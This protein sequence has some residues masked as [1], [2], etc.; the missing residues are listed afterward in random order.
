[1]IDFTP[2]EEYERNLPVYEQ[3]VDEDFIQIKMSSFTGS[4][5]SIV[6]PLS[7]DFVESQTKQLR[8]YSKEYSELLEQLPWTETFFST[9][10]T[11]NDVASLL[12][13]YKEINKLIVGENF[14]LCNNFLDQIK[15]SELSDTLL[16]GLLRLT[17]NWSSKL[18]TWSL[19]LHNARN[20]II[21][22]GYDSEALLKGLV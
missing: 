18:P 5:K 17:S 19:L 6:F 16:V 8:A 13:Y 12:P 3:Y 7:F 15:A 20:E 21:N 1:M 9:S 10:S 2:I 22:R 11:L 4:G 14:E